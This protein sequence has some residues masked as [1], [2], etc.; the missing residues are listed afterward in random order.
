V[1]VEVALV[2]VVA[3]LAATVAGVSGFGGAV[4]LLPALV[5][6]FGARDAVVVLTVAQLAGNGSRVYLNRADVDGAVVGRFAIGA[7]PFA[8]VGGAVFVAIP[9]A[10]LTRAL[11]AFLLAAVA[12]RHLRRGPAEGFPARRF[13]VFGGAF[14]FLSAIVGSVGPIMAPFFLAYGLLKASYI[15]T[16]AACTLVMHTTKLV[17]YGGGGVLKGSAIIAGLALTPVM[18]VGSWTGKRI[19]DRL[20][21]DAFVLLIDVV[22]IVSGALLLVRS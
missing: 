19:L 7:V 16:E 4:I 12:W 8:L 3:F 14:G 1:V 17:A 9:G 2:A 10:A 6:A 20:P 21:E 22:L 11:G 5:A 18:F 15:G 13:I